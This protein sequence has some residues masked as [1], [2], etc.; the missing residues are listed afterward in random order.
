MMTQRVAKRSGNPWRIVRESEKG[1]DQRARGIDVEAAEIDWL[2]CAGVFQVDAQIGL[3]GV[4][5]TQNA[6]C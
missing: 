6:H 3:I 2:T 4:N 1:S 5:L